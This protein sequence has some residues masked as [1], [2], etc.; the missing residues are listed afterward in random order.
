VVLLRNRARI[1]LMSGK[2][3]L[4]MMSTVYRTSYDRPEGLLHRSNAREVEY[5]RTILTRL[6][7]RSCHTGFRKKAGLVVSVSL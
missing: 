1:K 4:I 6:R 5:K 7:Q 2:I 3:V